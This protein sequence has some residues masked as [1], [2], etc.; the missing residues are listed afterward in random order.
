[1]LASGFYGRMKM[2]G[3]KENNI[4]YKGK[5]EGLGTYQAHTS[6]NHHQRIQTNR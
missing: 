5:L 3:Q 2:I 1:M 4:S 6:P